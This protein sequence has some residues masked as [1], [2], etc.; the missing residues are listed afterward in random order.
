[1]TSTVR[2]PSAGAIGISMT[3][4]GGTDTARP[5]AMNIPNVGFVRRR[6]P[7]ISTAVRSNRNGGSFQ[8]FGEHEE[9]AAMP[10]DLHQPFTVEFLAR[11][12]EQ[13]AG[14]NRYGLVAI[15]P[16]KHS[17]ERTVQP[18]ETGQGSSSFFIRLKED[19]H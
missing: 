16:G 19:L 5:V 6:S 17:D 3:V 11:E 2:T 7:I 12:I 15:R 10:D 14:R 13:S 8:V 18:M 4:P 1:M 9:R